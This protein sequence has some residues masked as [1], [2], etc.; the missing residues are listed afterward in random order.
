M[1]GREVD[2]EW[3]NH[4]ME[5]NGQRMASTN[6]AQLTTFVC[7]VELVSVR[8]QLQVAGKC[9]HLRKTTAER[10]NQASKPASQTHAG[11]P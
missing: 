9:V 8:W 5:W 2:K 3:K 6:T 7:A 11:M 1:D 10:P 4:G